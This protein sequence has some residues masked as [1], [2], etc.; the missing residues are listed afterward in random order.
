MRGR[1]LLGGIGDIDADQSGSKLVSVSHRDRQGQPIAVEVVEFRYHPGLA[2]T[3][4]AVSHS[5]GLVCKPEL[6]C[7]I[8]EN[9][10]SVRA[11]THPSVSRENLSANNKSALRGEQMLF[12]LG[13][14]CLR[15][16]R[17]DGEDRAT[18]SLAFRR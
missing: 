8:R 14:A 1:C 7:P 9:R 10:E 5:E 15:S 6:S 2:A 3:G 4:D 18:A 11:K 13:S 12:A 17:Q 16:T